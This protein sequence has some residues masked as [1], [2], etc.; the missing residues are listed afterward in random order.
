MCGQGFCPFFAIYGQLLASLVNGWIRAYLLSR[1]SHP[2]LFIHTAENLTLFDSH[3]WIS[4]DSLWFIKKKKK[5]QIK[6]INTALFP[7]PLCH[8]WTGKCN[9]SRKATNTWEYDHGYIVS[10]WQSSSV[11]GS[12]PLMCGR[13][14][15][16]G[17]GLCIVWAGDHEM[18]PSRNSRRNQVIMLDIGFPNSN[19]TRLQAHRVQNEVLDLKRKKKKSGSKLNAPKPLEDVTLTWTHKCFNCI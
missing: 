16:L 17:V 5:G 11:H 10:Q 4:P 14:G 12:Q 1:S 19:K 15:R 6:L 9:I 8:L 7:N 18:L 13:L 2:L 3:I